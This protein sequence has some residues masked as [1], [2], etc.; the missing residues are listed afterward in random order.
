MRG[1]CGKYLRKS[2]DQNGNRNTR[3]NNE[4]IDQLEKKDII[5]VLSLSIDAINI[6]GLYSCAVKRHRVAGWVEKQVHVA[7]R[8]QL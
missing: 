6:N 1:T 8:P 2:P 4:G 5:V 3:R 7:S